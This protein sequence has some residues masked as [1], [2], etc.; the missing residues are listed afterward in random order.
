MGELSSTC[1]LSLIQ[2]TLALPMTVPL[3][4]QCLSLEGR[5][6]SIAYTVSSGQAIDSWA[7]APLENGT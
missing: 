4:S 7:S 5:L 6:Y 1:W 3:A 2:G